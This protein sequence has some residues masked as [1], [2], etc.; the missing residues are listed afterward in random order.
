VRD[1]DPDYTPGRVLNIIFGAIIAGFSLGQVAPNLGAFAAGTSQISMWSA[2]T[3]ALCTYRTGSYVCG[4]DVKSGMR[5]RECMGACS[6]A[7]CC[8]RTRCW[9]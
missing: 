2:C 4:H 3:I 1:R 7:E 8:C 5:W 6:Y 9:I